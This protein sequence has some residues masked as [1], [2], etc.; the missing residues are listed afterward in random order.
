MSPFSYLALWQEVDVLL[1]S[2]N[3]VVDLHAVQNPLSQSSLSRCKMSGVSRGRF[4]L[5]PH[6]ALSLNVSTKTTR[7]FRRPT[8]PVRHVLARSLTDGRTTRLEYR[9]TNGRKVHREDKSVNIMQD[10]VRLGD[11][12][13]CLPS[14]LS[15]RSRSRLGQ[16]IRSTSP[17]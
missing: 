8:C 11:P 15:Q 4:V 5:Q 6:I 14:P 10:A 9:C 7:L 2:L 1:V 12:L 17:P 13:S 3:D 16:E